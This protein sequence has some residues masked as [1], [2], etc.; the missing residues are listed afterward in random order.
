MNFITY[1]SGEKERLPFN[2][3]DKGGVQYPEGNP[4][5]PDFDLLDDQMAAGA[6]LRNK[7]DKNKPES[8]K[9]TE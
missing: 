1:M 7:D 3:D 4:A 2:I 5:Q 8:G 6:E 9:K